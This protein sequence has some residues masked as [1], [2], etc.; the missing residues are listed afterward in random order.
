MNWKWLL[1]AL[2]RI[3]TIVFILFFFIVFV[4][5]WYFNDLPGWLPWT[6]LPIFVYLFHDRKN[7]RSKSGKQTV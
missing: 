4:Y 6:Y 5:Q 2:S 1:I 3:Y 7:I